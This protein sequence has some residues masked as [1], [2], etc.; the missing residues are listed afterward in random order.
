MC[1]N[2]RNQRLDSEYYYCYPFCDHDL[3]FGSDLDDLKRRVSTT[4]EY[5]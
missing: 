1:A 5:L 2:K 4:S 3:S